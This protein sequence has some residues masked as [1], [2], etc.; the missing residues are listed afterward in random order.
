MS[1]NLIGLKQ[2]AIGASVLAY[3]GAVLYGDIMFLQIVGVAF[4]Q[5][6]IG[7]SMAIAGA[8]VTALSAIVLPVAL[9]WWFAPGLQF[10]GGMIYWAA[11]IAALTLNSMLAFQVAS[12]LP[13]DSL[14]LV[15]RTWS[16][17]TP[18][19]AVVGWGLMYLLDQSHKMRHAQ[20]EQEA[21]QI[22]AYA[23]R[24]RSAA[25]SEGV[26]QA[27]DE[28]AQ[29]AAWRYAQRLSGGHV[30]A[31]ANSQEEEPPGGPKAPRRK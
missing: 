30:P 19:L 20:A 1:R 12:G 8:L 4:P 25:R 9:H 11:D 6:G 18:L 29:A 26:A 28:A 14:M 24:L 17:A 15:W 21:D 23:E 22:D 2:L 7:A 13:L 16:P 10:I 31:V 27:I 3:V 5:S